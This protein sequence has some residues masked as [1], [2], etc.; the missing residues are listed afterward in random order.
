M[1]DAY[2][3]VSRIPSLKSVPIFNRFL[4]QGFFLKRKQTKNQAQVLI[5]DTGVKIRNSWNHVLIKLLN[6]VYFP[7][8]W[9]FIPAFDHQIIKILW[10]KLR[11]FK[12]PS[13]PQKFN[14]ILNLCKF[15]I[16]HCKSQMKHFP[17]KNT[18]RPNITF[19]F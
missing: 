17:H 5:M 10:T 6:T 13:I 3:M 7:R 15:S 11:Y 1:I 16:G 2:H 4:D 19:F 14:Q 9:I 18:K 8:K 12:P